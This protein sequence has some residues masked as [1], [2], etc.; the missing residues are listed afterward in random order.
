MAKIAAWGMTISLIIEMVL[1]GLWILTDN[2]SF[3]KL[4]PGI[5]FIWVVF[6]GLSEVFG[7]KSNTNGE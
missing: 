4:L 6:F 2:F 1:L 7:N 5:G 3:A